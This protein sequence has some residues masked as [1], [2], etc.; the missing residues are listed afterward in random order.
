[1]APGTTQ[2][3]SVSGQ[4]SPDSASSLTP[5]A[6]RTEGLVLTHGE[7]VALTGVDLC[8]DAGQVIAL[9]GPNGSGKSTLMDSIAGVHRPSAGT[10]EVFGR[11]PGEVPIAYVFQATHVPAHL[12]LTVRE[13]VRMGRYRT[14][15]LLRR[16]G[17]DGREAV[18]RAIQRLDL[19]DLANRQLQE[20]SGGQRQRVLV[21]QGLAA[22]ADM[23][24]LDEPM[25]GLDVV[26]RDRILR[27]IREE[28]DAG[29]TV[30]FSTHDMGEAFLA[31]QV[32]L[33]AGRLVS[34]GEPAV[35]LARKNLDIAYMSQL[36]TTGDGSA[37]LDDAHHHDHHHHVLDHHHDHPHH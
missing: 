16:I 12:P 18:A 27:I 35:A 5:P 15:G 11:P 22:E 37:I 2:Q 4:P 29:R 17:N 34:V 8:L 30:M 21:A 26:A 3:A 20:L 14:T 19:G 31:D 32:V 25:T 36:G 10:I 23:L 13:V 33:L 28:V 9:I 24:M 7:R 6:I 1:M